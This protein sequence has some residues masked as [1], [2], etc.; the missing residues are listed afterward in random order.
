MILH[1]ASNTS[2]ANSTFA[3]NDKEAIKQALLAGLGFTKQDD[4]TYIQT[5][6]GMP[7]ALSLSGHVLN[8]YGFT[9]DANGVLNTVLI[10][11]GDNGTTRLQEL[12]IKEVNGKL[13]L[14][15][16]NSAAYI[17]SS[18]YIDGVSYINTP[19]VLQNMLKEYRSMDEAAV[20]NGKGINGVRESQVDEVDS[21]I[22]DEKTGWDVLVNGDNI[23]EKHHDSFGYRYPRLHSFL[24]QCG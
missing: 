14:Y 23:D 3:Y 7:A 4:G 5:Q 15:R 6:E 17:N 20:W 24:H 18:T 16:S 1:A 2:A 21:E 22:A 13:V 11:D 19:E 9:T 12:L 8:S 10:A